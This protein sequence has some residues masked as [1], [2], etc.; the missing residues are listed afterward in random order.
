MQGLGTGISEFLR[1]AS[2]RLGSDVHELVALFLSR[3]TVAK[4]YSEVS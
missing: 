4:Y 2:E 1:M 3:S